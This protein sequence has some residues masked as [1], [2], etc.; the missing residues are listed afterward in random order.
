MRGRV[1]VK[2]VGKK[3]EAGGGMVEG[4]DGERMGVEGGRRDQ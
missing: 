1:G 4:G 3:R 2:N